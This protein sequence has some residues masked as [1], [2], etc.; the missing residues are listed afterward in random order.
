MV[1]GQQMH[2]RRTQDHNE[3]RFWWK[4]AMYVEAQAQLH[5]LG[6]LIRELRIFLSP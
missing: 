6:F 3:V 2:R 4:P 1:P 5:C